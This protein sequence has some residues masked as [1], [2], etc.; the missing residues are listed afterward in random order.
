[1]ACRALHF[2]PKQRVLYRPPALHHS[3]LRDKE[4]KEK[5]KI[6]P[7]NSVSRHRNASGFL[8]LHPVPGNVRA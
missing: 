7:V 1:M 4:S 6:V 2:P 3:S 5:H 8:F